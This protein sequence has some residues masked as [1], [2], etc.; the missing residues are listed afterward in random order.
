MQERPVPPCSQPLVLCRAGPAL[1]RVC[2]GRVNPLGEV[3]FHFSLG[4]FLILPSRCCSCGAAPAAPLAAATRRNAGDERRPLRAL[5]AAPRPPLSL[6]PL[7][8]R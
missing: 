3:L 4:K 1:P 6:A 7:L 2:D 5:G 8:G